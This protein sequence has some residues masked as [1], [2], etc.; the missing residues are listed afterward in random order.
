MTLKAAY[1]N[2]LS[3]WLRKPDCQLNVN[4]PIYVVFE[5]LY[6]SKPSELIKYKDD[7][8]RQMKVEAVRRDQRKP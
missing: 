8:D 6:K 7:F 4:M 2:R 3:G 5:T 1:R